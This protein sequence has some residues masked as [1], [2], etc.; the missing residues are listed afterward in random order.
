ME[1]NTEYIFKIDSLTNGRAAQYLNSVLRNFLRSIWMI[2]L[3]II[4]T[5]C[6]IQISLAERAT[7]D[8]AIRSNSIVSLLHAPGMMIPV[9]MENERNKTHINCNIGRLVL[10]SI[11]AL[12][13]I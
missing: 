12:F 2:V 10:A 6:I 11:Q 8:P 3:S 4:V 7:N 13:P 5:L 9:S 1:K